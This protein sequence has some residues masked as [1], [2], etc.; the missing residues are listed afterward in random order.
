MLRDCQ[1]EARVVPVQNSLVVCGA[2]MT[3]QCEGPCFN[4]PNFCSPQYEETCWTNHK[5]KK[6]IRICGASTCTD[7]EAGLEHVE[8][9]VKRE[10]Q[11]E[12]EEEEELKQLEQLEEVSSCSQQRVGEVCA[13]VNCKFTTEKQACSTQNRTETVRLRTNRCKICQKRKTQIINVDERCED[14]LFK[15]CRERFTVAWKKFCSD[16]SESVDRLK[17]LL[18]ATESRSAAEGHAKSDVSEFESLLDRSLAPVNS[19]VIET[20][21]KIKI[22]DL[23]KDSVVIIT[24]SPVTTTQPDTK[25]TTTSP[26]VQETSQWQIN[27]NS[28]EVTPRVSDVNVNAK[29]AFE[30][31]EKPVDQ[32]EVMT[33]TTAA[34]VVS[35]TDAALG[36]GALF[37]AMIVGSTEAGGA[38]YLG[39][40][41]VYYDPSLQV[42]ND[43]SRDLTEDLSTT[44]LATTSTSST[45]TI[46]TTTTTT[47][48]TATTTTTT[49]KPV[50]DRPLSPKDLLRLCFLNN[51]GCEFGLNEINRSDEGSSR[52]TTT[53]STTTTAARTTTTAATRSSR[54]TEK[55]G[56]DK[57]I[58]DKF[59]LCFEFGICSEEDIQ[60]ATAG[61]AVA[62]VT[63]ARPPRSVLTT[64]ATTT[65]V[66]RRSDRHDDLKARAV[67]CI[68]RGDC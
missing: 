37:S 55:S 60:L 64:T 23:N 48:T 38:V 33:T 17:K 27:S 3:R 10:E 46:T 35:G 49:V 34:P 4:C 65:A 16:Y 47:T 31:A 21:R 41:A 32:A 28:V 13:P 42:L 19:L 20:L 57:A 50:V 1:E 29:Y 56:K 11:V 9:V 54:K 44:T 66:F 15:D 22:Q 59:R 30:D 2:S 63:T 12:E 67:A 26:S 61:P 7:V 52:T 43:R 5:V 6:I 68:W 58:S 53:V 36:G 40:G 25:T 39:G 51:L 45:T 8:A 14:V 62:A 24:P 18:N